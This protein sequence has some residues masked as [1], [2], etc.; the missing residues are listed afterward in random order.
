MKLSD[1]VFDD[2]GMSD[3]ADRR[4]FRIVCR[5][6]FN[7]INKMRTKDRFCRIVFENWKVFLSILVQ[8][9]WLDIHRRHALRD[10]FEEE[11]LPFDFDTDEDGRIY[12]LE[13]EVRNSSNLPK[14]IHRF[15]RLEKLGIRGHITSLPLRELQTE[16]LPLVTTLEIGGLDAFQLL[17]VCPSVECLDLYSHSHDQF[18]TL[19]N[20]LESVEMEK[21][22]Y[23]N[24]CES[25]ISGEQWAKLMLDV[26][27][28]FP[29]LEEL[30]ISSFSVTD[31]RVISDRLRSDK[32]WVTSK[33]LRRLSMQFPALQTEEPNFKAD[34]LTLP[35][36]FPNV[37]DIEWL[38]YAAF[39]MD[40]DWRYA[41]VKNRVGR[42]IVRRG[43]GSSRLPL[44]A[45]PIV[46]QRAQRKVWNSNFCCSLL[47]HSEESTACL[48]VTGIY[49]LLRKGSALIGR[50]DLVGGPEPSPP[51]AKR[52]K[53]A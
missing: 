43:G 23:I 45:W 46:L 30:H 52:Q 21:L 32:S 17:H 25:D 2:M 28:R 50:R 31:F 9:G 48:V 38:R 12:F 26:V 22:Q 36:F 44:A 39:C 51:P 27:P 34:I 24:F 35:K 29:H 47:V 42:R 18:D 7:E 20:L 13:F 41:M 37:D 53:R 4:Q 5:E 3:I 40:P 14:G 6:Y 1:P 8:T 16:K 33:S 15:D 10:Y 11:D 19:L 49:Y